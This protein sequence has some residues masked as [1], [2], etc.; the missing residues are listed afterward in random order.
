MIR[1]CKI[2]VASLIALSCPATAT[3]QET[4]P[5]WDPFA[6]D[7]VILTNWFEGEFDNEEQV[8]FQED[9]RSNT[10]EVDRH[11]SYHAINVRLDLPQFGEHV[12]YVE[13]YIEDDPS[14]VIRQRFVTFESDLE[15][16]AIRM[17]QGF[18]KDS[19]DYIGAHR[20]L[21]RFSNLEPDDVF[22]MRDLQADNQCDVFW[23]RV[24]DQYEGAMIEKGCSLGTTGIG[25]PRYSV[26]EMILSEN[27]YWRVDSAIRKDNGELHSGYAVDRPIKMRRADRY[28]CSG[29]FNPEQGKQQL[30]PFTIHNQGG[31]VTLTREA[32]GQTFELLLRKKEYPYFNELPDFL[33]FSIRRGDEEK[34]ML[35]S[36]HDI[37]ARRIGL[38]YGGTMAIGCNREG[39]K[40]RETLEQLKLK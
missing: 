30:E 27:K 11:T 20:D 35:F 39:Y 32:D 13:E 31:T 16:G 26:F 10:S 4:V 19:K 24:G 17:Q 12:F 28:E 23:R 40:F 9:P 6:R 2:L 5:R 15:A 18:L 33:Y 38:N 1:F 36:V 14:K 21:S 34:S 37:D 3:A 22:F 8:W 29:Y 7:L 25:P